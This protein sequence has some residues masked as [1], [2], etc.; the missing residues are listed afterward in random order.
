MAAEVRPGGGVAQ[1]RSLAVVRHGVEGA[2]WAGGRIPVAFEQAS[3]WAGAWGEPSGG[4][5]E[6]EKLHEEAAS[7]LHPSATCGGRIKERNK[8]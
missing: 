5:T 6:K 3:W 7:D 1:H 8:P 2:S 4:T